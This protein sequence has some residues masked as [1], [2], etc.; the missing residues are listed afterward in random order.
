MTSVTLHNASSKIPGWILWPSIHI[1]WSSMTRVTLHDIFYDPPWQIMWPFRINYVILQGKLCLN[2]FLGHF[3][4]FT[5]FFHRIFYVSVFSN[6][7]TYFLTDCRHNRP[8][9][10]ISKDCIVHYQILTINNTD[11]VIIF[12]KH[13]QHHYTPKINKRIWTCT[14]IIS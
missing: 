5:F 14:S 11:H 7:K 12:I 13:I 3:H 8:R 4:T 9:T 6:G 1:M 2:K 10:S